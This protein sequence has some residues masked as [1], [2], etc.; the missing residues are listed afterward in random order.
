MLPRYNVSDHPSVLAALAVAGGLSAALERQLCTLTLGIWHRIADYCLPYSDGKVVTDLGAGDG[1]LGKLLQ[2]GSEEY[3]GTGDGAADALISNTRMR[4]PGEM[5]ETG[6]TG[7]PMNKQTTAVCLE[8]FGASDGHRRVGHG[9]TRMV[10]LACGETEPSQAVS[11][12]AEVSEQLANLA[13]ANVENCVSG[14]AICRLAV[15][16]AEHL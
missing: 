13:A 10:F 4:M 16:H 11:Y 15:C 2:A 8:R 1:T 12:I 6:A 9:R 3:T 5:P 7:I 14:V